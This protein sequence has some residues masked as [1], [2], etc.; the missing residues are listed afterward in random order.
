MSTPCSVSAVCRAEDH[1]AALRIWS[2]RHHD[3]GRAR[4]QVCCRL[5]AVLCELIPGGIAK[6]IIAVQ[7]AVVLEAIE[8]TGAVAAARCELAAEFIDDLRR[9]DAQL[10][11]T[12]KRLGVAVRVRRPCPPGHTACGSTRC[13]RGPAHR[14]LPQVD[15]RSV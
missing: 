14:G 2:R 9:I 1:A 4:N 15:Q 5:H 12:Q 10:R 13:A 7:A 3:L 8:P 11:D 6:E